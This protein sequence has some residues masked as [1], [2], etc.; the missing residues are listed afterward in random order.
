MGAIFNIIATPM[1]YVMEWIYNT[2]QNY[3]Y[4]ILAFALLAKFIL[5]PFSIK[6]KRSMIATQRI[7]PKLRE[8]QKKY[9]HDQEKYSR[10]MQRLY[11]D[12][13]A[14]PM[15]GCGTSLLTLPVMLGLYYVVT[16]PMTYMMHIPTEEVAAIAEFLGLETTKFGFQMTACGMISEGYEALKN[17]SANIIPIDFTFFGLDLSQT[18]SFKEP[19]FNWIIPILSAATS[20]GY[21]HVMTT[22]NQVISL[23]VTD[24]AKQAEDE[25]VQQM[26]KSMNLM[27]PLMSGYFGFVL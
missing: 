20:W 14:S 5:A 24:G 18:P 27:M 1:G 11:K 13:G 10:E 19:A 23:K 8:L 21:T 9:G 12:N 7:N 3:G 16:M 17:I 22:M 15:G 2:V 4:S 6:Q 25:K 26:N